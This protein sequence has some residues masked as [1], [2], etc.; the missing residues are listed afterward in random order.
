[1]KLTKVEIEIADRWMSKREKQLAKWPRRRWLMLAMFSLFA[2]LGYLIGSDGMRSIDDD[3]AIDLQAS[4]AIGGYPSPD[5]EQ[6]WVVGS[7]MKIA[8]VLE[9]RYQVV[10]YALMQVVLGYMILIWNIGMMVIIILRWNTGERDALIC[11]LLRSKLTE[12]ET[13]NRTGT[14]ATP[15]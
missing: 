1:M 13:D 5:Q 6:R 9:A 15:S 3:K 4:L 2:I 7:M 11:K 14:T 8:K 10:T 12:L